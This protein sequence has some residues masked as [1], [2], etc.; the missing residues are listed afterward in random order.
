MRRR[1]PRSTLDRSSAASDV[2]KRQDE[3]VDR[4]RCVTTLDAAV[5]HVERGGGE[6]EERI[7]AALGAFRD[8]DAGLIAERAARIPLQHL[9][10]RAHFRHRT[11][12]VGPGVFIPRPETETLVSYAVAAVRDSGVDTPAVI[13]LCTGSGAV[14]FAVKAEVPSA[15]VYAVELDP[16]AHGW[17]IANRE[18]L[19]LDVEIWL[20]DARTAYEELLGL[21]DVVTCN[22]PYIPATDPHLRQGDLPR[23]PLS[24]L[25]S[26]ADGLDA[27]RQI[28]C[29][30]TTCLKPG[31]LLALEHGFDQDAAVRTLLAVAG[32]ERLETRPDLPGNPPATPGYRSDSSRHHSPG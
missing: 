18:R 11:L 2:Y 19:G 27:L 7:F 8:Q 12:A 17:A 20:G 16:L 30:A 15:A 5:R 14:A 1:P 3:G 4:A 24:A 29:Q 6:I 26:G 32:F 21:V 9:T 13:D 23:E 31:G 25:A 10:G 22:P 28:T